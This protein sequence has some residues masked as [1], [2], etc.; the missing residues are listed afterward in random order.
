MAR[1]G[2][3]RRRPGAGR[4]GQGDGGGSSGSLPATGPPAGDPGRRI[5][6]RRHRSHREAR[7][8]SRD[9]P[10]RSR[11][12]SRSGSTTPPYRFGGAAGGGSWPPAAIDSR[13]LVSACTFSI[14]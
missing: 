9:I 5:C 11:M 14:R 3:T 2:S 12:N 8:T 10:S 1:G 13:M 7:L 6:S 4:G